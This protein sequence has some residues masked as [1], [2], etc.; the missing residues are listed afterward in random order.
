MPARSLTH[1]IREPKSGS[2]RRCKKESEQIDPDEL[3]QKLEAHLAEQKK[4]AEVRRGRAIAKK[5][6]AYHHVPKVA[7]AAFERTTTPVL[8]EKEKRRKY[9]HRLAQLA[10][11][12]HAEETVRPATG[13]FDLRKTQAMDHARK[14]RDLLGDRNQFQWT[15]HL[16]DAAQFDRQRNLNKVPQRTF[17]ADHIDLHQS[18]RFCRPLSTG[19]LNWEEDP[20]GSEPIYHT[21]LNAKTLL[22]QT[23]NDRQ[24]W[25]Q[26][27]EVPVEVHRSVK[28]RVGPFL[29]KTDSMWILK[30]KREPKTDVLPETSH[31]APSGDTKSKK[32]IFL[33][34]GMGLGLF[35]KR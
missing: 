35:T 10:L 11:K 3:R 17:G 34:W 12:H 13:S 26:R 16:E 24:D 18:A 2:T 15:R 20:E 9:V 33:A 19:D 14:Q 22:I 28:E 4:Q 8:G 1:P 30:S 27:D 21:K 25:E 29:R 5:E 31:S 6:S 7:A 32:S 23:A